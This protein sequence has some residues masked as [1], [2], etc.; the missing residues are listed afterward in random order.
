MLKEDSRLKKEFPWRAFAFYVTIILAATINELFVH[1]MSEIIEAEPN[2]WVMIVVL[3]VAA[4]MLVFFFATLAQYAVVRFPTQWI[5]KDKEV[6]D[7]DMWKAFFYSNGIG[8][9]ITFLAGFVGFQ[10]NIVFMLAMS[11]VVT[12]LF[13]YIYFNSREKPVHIKRAVIIVQAAWFII[14]AVSSIGSLYI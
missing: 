5:A 12:F 2:G 4:N 1:G 8:M 3:G 7:F 9:L 11:A 10:S 13:I 6:Y 14:S